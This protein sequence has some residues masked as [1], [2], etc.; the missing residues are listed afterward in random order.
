MSIK[1][2]TEK[3]IKLTN[4][5]IAFLMR[6][7]NVPKLPHDVSFVPFSK[8]DKEL[9]KFN[10]KLLKEIS[11]KEEHVVIAEEPKN[12]KDGWKLIPVNF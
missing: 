8:S 1:K 12:S 5:L 10:E 7:K 9:N 11:N 6:G 4:K 3:N 2:Q